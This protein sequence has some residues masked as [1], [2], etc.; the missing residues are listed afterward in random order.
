MSTRNLRRSLDVSQ[1]YGDSFAFFKITIHC[2]H[3]Q[4]KRLFCCEDGSYKLYVEDG[5]DSELSLRR[6][7][8]LSGN[9]TPAVQHA[10]C[11]YTY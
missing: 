9:R 6:E 5:F 10:A 3:L 4:I 11:L 2:L 8:V 7:E 1:I